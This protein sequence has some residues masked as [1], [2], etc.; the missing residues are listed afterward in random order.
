M[1]VSSE[2]R[3]VNVLVKSDLVE[4]G[5]ILRIK[6]FYGIVASMRY[7]ED[8]KIG[9]KQ[10]LIAEVQIFGKL[11]GRK[12]KKVK[13]PVEPYEDVFLAEKNE[14]ESILSYDDRISI[15]TVYGTRARAYLNANEYDRHFAI[16]ASTGSGKS[17]TAANIIK[18]LSL[19]GLPIIVVDTHGEY[20]KIFS[21]LS[22]KNPLNI[23]I[24]TVKYKRQGCNQIKIPVSNLEPSDFH[25]FTFFSEPQESAIAMLIEH[26]GNTDYVLQDMIKGCDK[27]DINIIH[28]GTIQALK[29]KLITLERV[30]KE[31]FDK[32]GTD[33]SK[34]VSPGK[35]TIIDASLAPQGVRRSV[36]SYLARE[37]LELRINKMNEIGT[38]AIDYPLLFVVEEA[39]NYCGSDL[40]HSCKNQIQR[41]ASEGRKFGIGLCVISQKPSRID[42]D[43]LS[44]CNTGI[45]MHITNPRDK[46]H[47]RKSFESINDTIISDLDRLDVGECIIAGAMLD[48]PFLMCTVDYIEVE[49]ERKSKFNFKIPEK[50]KIGKSEYF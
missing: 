29:R 2:G 34:L 23:E 21:A 20:Q 6:E 25:H 11:S 3:T 31:V 45:Y 50:A 26:L 35:I 28:E 48:I 36:I 46:E 18:E 10:K 32:F 8:E 42:E 1:V 43:I 5:S 22:K 24:Y 37:L 47:I 9:S 44:Q 39:H 15:G 16:L 13:K 38:N 30:F 4:I 7:Q 40:N 27:L 14:L 19:L 12:I 17:Y 49:K 33:V 41:I